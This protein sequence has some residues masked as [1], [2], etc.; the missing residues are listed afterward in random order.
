LNAAF[1]AVQAAK[2][3][4]SNF[5]ILQ[6]AQWIIVQCS[7]SLGFLGQINSARTIRPEDIP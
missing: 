2:V 3:F 1:A 6:S 4:P 7:H 5:R